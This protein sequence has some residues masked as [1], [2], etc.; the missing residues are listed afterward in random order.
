MAL[1]IGYWFG[2][3]LADRHPNLR[4]LCLLVVVAAVLLALVPFVADP[5]LSLSVDAFDT[6]LVGAFAGSLFGVLALVAV[7]VLMLG[8]VSPWAIRLKLRSVEDSGEIGRAHV[9]DL[10]RRLA[11]RD[12]PRRAAADPAGRDPADVP[13]LRAWPWRS[14]PRWGSAC[15]GWPCPCAVAGAAAVPVGTSRPPGDGA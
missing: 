14:W 12:V 9:R 6:R 15:A 3:R 1:S 13:R 4:G 11:G 10:D 7:P 8:A 5:F 2:G